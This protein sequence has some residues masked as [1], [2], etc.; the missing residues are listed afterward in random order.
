MEPG[1]QG[2]MTTIPVST[3]T[4]V[5]NNYARHATTHNERRFV[6][7]LADQLGNEIKSTTPGFD[8]PGWLKQCGVKQEWATEAV[9]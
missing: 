9:A 5:I 7:E 2:T 4:K 3:V 8:E 6:F 1:N